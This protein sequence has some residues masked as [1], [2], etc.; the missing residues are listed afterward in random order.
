[1][2]DAGLFI[3]LFV[4]SSVRVIDCLLVCDCVFVRLFVCLL[5]LCVCVF[6]CIFDCMCV[7]LSVCLFFVFI[8]CV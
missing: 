4:G 2:L 1:M 3:C 6:V 7:S 5:S 8:S